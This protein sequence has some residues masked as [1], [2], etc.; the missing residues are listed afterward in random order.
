MTAGNGRHEVVN[1]GKDVGKGA[2]GGVSPRKGDNFKEKKKDVDARTV[3]RKAESGDGIL[4][5]SGQQPEHK[6]RRRQRRA[7]VFKK[8]QPRKN[9]LPKRPGAGDAITNL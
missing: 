6:G 9:E 1:S 7:A 4:K 3:C 8:E 5:G 2:E